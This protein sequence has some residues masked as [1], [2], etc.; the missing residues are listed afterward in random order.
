MSEAPRQVTCPT[1]GGP[2]LY[3][4]AN[5]YRPF[6]GERCKQMDLGAWASERFA[7]PEQASDRVPGFED[8]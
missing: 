7:V 4:P 8:S 6:C 1:C 5:R 2:S 3:A